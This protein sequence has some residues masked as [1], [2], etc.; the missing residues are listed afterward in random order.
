[1][2]RSWMNSLP[3]NER[4]VPPVLSVG[5]V[6]SPGVASGIQTGAFSIELLSH[7]PRG[8]TLQLLHAPG[9]GEARVADVVVDIEVG[10]VHPYWILCN[11]C[12]LK[13][14]A[15]ARNPVEQTQQ[16]GADPRKVRWSRG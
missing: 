5:S 14:L 2:K 7:D 12:P 10:V 4:S 16:R 15:I 13:S 3:F 6:T 9:L 1:M 8:Q 11:R